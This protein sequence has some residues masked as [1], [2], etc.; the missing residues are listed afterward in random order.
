MKKL[1]L[2]LWLA[3]CGVAQAQTT[4][5][6][7]P[8]AGVFVMGMQV[9][10]TCGVATLTN[11]AVAYA[12]MDVTGTIC[13]GSG[14]GSGGLSVVD[15]AAFVEDTSRFTPS[16]CTFTDAANL[17]ATTQGM[18]RCTTKRAFVVDVDSSGNQLHSDLTAPIPDCAATPCINKIGTVY[19]VS[20]YPGGATAITAT[21]T[22]TTAATTATLAGTSGKTTFIC[23]LSI[24]SNA[25][26]AATGNATVTGVITATLNYNHWTAPLAS[27][28]GI[29]EMIYNPCVPASAANT[30][31]AVISPAPGSGGVVSVTATG[32]QL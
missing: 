5:T 32:Y 26:A 9:V 19:S 17:A 11:N 28:M 29:T 25:T 24:R 31:I 27:G 3:L 15:G 8:P 21:A 16:G 12:T 13:T 14:G 1:A 23:S 2:L 22:G 30:G 4:F 20:Q 7:P 18:V 10:T 6:M